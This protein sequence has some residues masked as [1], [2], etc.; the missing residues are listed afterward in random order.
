MPALQSD[1]PHQ[2]ARPAAGWYI[3]VVLTLAY[4][5]SF[6]DRQLLTLLIEPIRHD[7]EITD[8]QTLMMRAHGWDAPRA[9]LTIG[10]LMFVLGTAG[11]Y[12]GG[13]VADRLMARGRADAVLRAA[14]IGMADGLPFLVLMPAAA[15]ADLAVV[16]LGAAV[17]C[18][19]F[20]QGLPSTALQLITPNPLRAQTT[21]VYFFIGNLIAGSIG[22]T[23][24]ALLTDYVFRDPAKLGVAMVWV[25]AVVMPLSLLFLWL[26]FKP[27]RASLERAAVSLIQA[28]GKGSPER[29]V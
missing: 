22:P 14:F 28:S 12:S 5:C 27:Y 3:V 20:P 4:T 26:G 7:L 2:W 13:W 18:M 1:A 23:V 9:G 25:E 8:T 15:S 24:P 10:A 16:C 17:Y 29:G 6:I 19:A 11:V 21:A